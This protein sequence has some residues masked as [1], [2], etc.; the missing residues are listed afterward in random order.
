ME[1]MATEE[2]CDIACRFGDG[3]LAIEDYPQG[4]P[5]PGKDS[6]LRLAFFF[7]H[8]HCIS[9]HRFIYLCFGSLNVAAK[10]PYP[11]NDSVVIYIRHIGPGVCVG[12]AW[13]E[14]KEVQQVPQRLC[15]DILMVK[16]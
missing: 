16:Q 2:P 1:V 15:S 11:F 5:R 14:G 3:L 9:T 12:Q 10:H 7:L 13:Q 6:L 4:F 8:T